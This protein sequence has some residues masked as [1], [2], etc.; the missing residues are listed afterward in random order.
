MR[1]QQPPHHVGAAA[2]R[3]RHDD[4]DG[5]RRPQSAQRLARGKIA[6][7]ETAAAPVNTRGE[8]KLWWSQVHSLLDCWQGP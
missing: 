4:A 1:R 2:G 3:C 5:L 7:A 8:K 6:V